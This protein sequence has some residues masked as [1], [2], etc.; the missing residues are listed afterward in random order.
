MAPPCPTGWGSEGE[1]FT[2]RGTVPA[3]CWRGALPHST[4]PS[5]PPSPVA[6]TCCFCVGGGL[7]CLFA[8]VCS[9]MWLRSVYVCA[10]VCAGRRP[11]GVNSTT[12]L[13]IP[14]PP[15]ED[16]NHRVPSSVKQSGPT[17]HHFPRND[18][19]SGPAAEHS[20]CGFP[21]PPASARRAG[22]GSA[23]LPIRM[24]AAGSKELRAGSPFC[25]GR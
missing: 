9:R 4:A 18:G 16:E 11:A 20:L 3:P 2:P 23:R 13:R 14:S 6:D 12:T 22:E 19:R 1:Y 24:R 7:L 17:A 5:P 21:H 25:G 10:G 8:F 15:V